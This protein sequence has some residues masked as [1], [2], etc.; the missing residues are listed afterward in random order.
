MYLNSVSIENVRS[1]REFAWEVPQKKFTGWHVII[2]DNGSGKSSVL[3]AIA[4]ALVGPTEALAL[5]EDWNDWLRRDQ[6]AGSVRLYFDH[7]KDLDKFSGKGR[8]VEKWLLEVLLRFKRTDG[9]VKLSKGKVDLDPSR[10]IWGGKSGWFCASYG[11][12]RRFTGG[13]KDYEK[14]FYSNP[15]LARHLSI[16]EE[17][18]ALTESLQWLQDLRFK[19]LEKS[20]EGDLLE[21]LKRF[22][23][24]PDFLPHNAR[25]QEISSQGVFFVDGNGCEVLIDDLSD[26][27]RSMLSM[28][29]ELI[30]QLAATYGP[31]RIFDPEDASRVTAPGVVLVDEVDAHLHPTWQRTVGYWFCRHFPNMQFIVTTHS[32]LI[33]QAAELGSVYRLPRPGSDEP[34]EMIEGDELHRLIYGNVLDAYSTG[35]FGTDVTRSPSA[36]KKLHR[37]AALNLKELKESL[38]KQERRE[39]DQLR[40][41]MPTAAY[42]V[43]EC[44]SP[45]P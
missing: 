31:D 29:F 41:V 8:T 40:S 26:G 25:L 2:G 11:P 6:A 14:M 19:Q 37:L 5:R 27:Y 4:L 39:R 20:S 34:G 38:T 1:I 9:S 23:N 13:D 10:H 43:P 35:A 15:R 21:S 33:C 24:Q 28:T 45:D 17:S 22:V 30:R 42:T 7:N 44:S 3:R 32:P 36:L 16:F 12:F 18:V